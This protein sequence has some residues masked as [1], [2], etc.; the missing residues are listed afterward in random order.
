MLIHKIMRTLP[1]QLQLRLLFSRHH[2][3]ISWCLRAERAFNACYLRRLCLIGMLGK[4]LRPYVIYVDFVSC[5][6]TYSI[7]AECL[8]V[9]FSKIRLWHGNTVDIAHATF[10]SASEIGFLQNAV[11]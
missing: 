8:S 6:A 2:S 1:N 11:V 4:I 10:M 5:G 3:K 7:S 9:V